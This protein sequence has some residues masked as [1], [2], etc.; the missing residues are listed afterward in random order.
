MHGWHSPD[1]ALVLSASFWPLFPRALCTRILWC[2]PSNWASSASLDF[3][4]ILEIPTP[5]PASVKWETL[6]HT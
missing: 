5:V 3:T 4:S 6:G 2:E 1:A